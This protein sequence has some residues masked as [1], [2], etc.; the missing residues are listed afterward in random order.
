MRFFASIAA[1]VVLVTGLQTFAQT[2]TP[3]K[4]TVPGTTGD[5]GWQATVRMSDGRTFITD[6]G[7]AVDAAYARPASLPTR[8]VPA[9]RLEQFLKGSYKN[10]FG[11]AELKP[12]GTTYTAPGGLPL[13]AT[14]I[15]YLRRIGPRGLRFRS[16][17]DAQPVV[18]AAD[19]RAISVLMPVQ[20]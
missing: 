9:A 11:F 20:R 19:G 16:N 8:E 5:P 3:L 6:G 13:N 2:Q 7:L 4:P 18:V 15:D 10:E 12:A 14:Y 1:V 17:G